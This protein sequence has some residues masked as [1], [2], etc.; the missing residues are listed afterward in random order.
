MIGSQRMV[1][2]LLMGAIACSLVVIL[3]SLS[4]PSLAQSPSHV[5]PSHVSES[6]VSESSIATWMDLGRDRYEAGQIEGAITA[7]EEAVQLSQQQQVP[8]QQALAYTYLATAAGDLGQWQIAQSRLNQ[9]LDRLEDAADSPWAAHVYGRIFNGLGTLHYHQGQGEAAIEAWQ[10]AEDWYA[11]AD[12]DLGVLATQVSRAQGLQLLGHHRR[13]RRQL[14]QA[15]E[16][17][18]TL[19]NSEIKVIGLLNLGNSLLA[20][21]NSNEAE[22]VLGESLTTAESLAEDFDR[23]PIFTALGNLAR[24]QGEVEPALAYYEQAARSQ[25]PLTRIEAQINRSHL[26]LE[27]VT[28]EAIAQFQ[29]QFP[30]LQADL[31]NLPSSRRSIYAR[32]HLAQAWLNPLISAASEAEIA[33][34]LPYRYPI[35][36]LLAESVEQ[37]KTLG[38]RRAQ[39]YAVG[40]LAQLYEQNQQWS[41]S[42]SLTK[43]ALALS[44]G[45]EASDL[46]ARWQWQL[47][48]ILRARDDRTRAI[49]AYNAAIAN[50][51]QLRQDLVSIDPEAQFSFRE[52]VEPIYRQLV[53]L[54]LTPD[55]PQA[56]I[57][58]A[59][60]RQAREVVEALQLAELDDFFREACLDTQPVAID[61]IDA[62]AA[63]LYPIILPQRLAVILSIPGQPLS[64]AE[65]P[66]TQDQVNQSLDELAQLLN[67]IFPESRRLAV[68]QRLYDWLIRPL[69]PQLRQ[70]QP[71]TLVFVLDGKLR[72]LPMAVLHDGESYLV[73]RYGLAVAPSLRLLSQGQQGSITE[74]TVLMG[75]L[76]A[77]RQ[78]FAPLPGVEREVEQISAQL[79]ADVL[80]NEAFTTSDLQESFNRGRFSVLHLATHGQFSSDLDE[81]FLVTWDGRLDVN[82]LTG[83]LQARDPNLAGGIELLVLSAC[84]T[85]A[86]DNRAALGLAGFA[87]RSGAQSTLATLWSVGDLSTAQLMKTFYQILQEQPQLTKAEALREAQLTLLR[88]PEY[89]HPFYWSPF[90]LVGNWL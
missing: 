63:T 71:E 32:I 60:L 34:L 54:L 78:G 33:P 70:Q 47:G 13:S 43:T 88:S 53:D 48:R 46:Q 36:Q 26:L 10:Q 24:R 6:H 31:Q 55:S 17:L 22:R 73:E 29:D 25:T 37:A 57:P 65:T 72:N 80:I 2:H 27:T 51:Q 64:Y 18:Q 1:R 5:S 20:L 62:D 8:V 40:Q 90:I 30:S 44:E 87:V 23:S 69:E 39:A 12:D 83:L 85:A 16:Q 4:H 14:D 19:P 50:V 11:Q 82:Q 76:S 58:Q 35:A 52:Q 84:Q 86:G 79:S 9:A 81:T 41:E 75:G 3:S 28:P 89:S 56:E 15:L 66:L 49:D 61:E 59:N 68:S 42:Q 67:P 45:L 77:S 21:G 38:D 74:K 7:W